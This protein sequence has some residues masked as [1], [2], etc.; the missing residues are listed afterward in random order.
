ML[1]PNH[2][3]PAQRNR[4]ATDVDRGVMVLDAAK[5]IEEHTRKLLGVCRLRDVPIII[6]VNK[7][8]PRG[9]RPV[10]SLLMRYCNYRIRMPFV[11]TIPV[12]DE[13]GAAAC[14]YF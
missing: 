5:G 14:A 10:Q 3:H 13:S 7:A 12:A 8:R 9:P 4:A 11:R 1:K 6:F 2:N